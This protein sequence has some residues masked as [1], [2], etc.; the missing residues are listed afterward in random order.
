MICGKLDEQRGD[1]TLNVKETCQRSTDFA[2]LTS[3]GL[4]RLLASALNIQF[5]DRLVHHTSFSRIEEVDWSAS[6][7]FALA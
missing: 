6:P 7:G 1:E 4:R 3:F 5:F 2:Y